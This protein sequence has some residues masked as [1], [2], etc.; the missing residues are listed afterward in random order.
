MLIAHLLQT[1]DFWVFS[2]K[3]EYKFIERKKTVLKSENK[4]NWGYAHY[5]IPDFIKNEN[6]SSLMTL[7][8]LMVVWW[9]RCW[10]GIFLI[11]T[12]NLIIATLDAG[13]TQV[14]SSSWKPTSSTAAGFWP[15]G[16]QV[17]NSTTAIDN[18]ECMGLEIQQYSFIRL[19]HHS[20]NQSDLTIP[21]GFV[22]VTHIRFGKCKCQQRSKSTGLSLTSWTI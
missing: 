10:D 20:D 14:C 6:S 12:H 4:K 5:G 17:K 13:R 18:F 2:F 3:N 16:K 19:W 21:L 9:N 8:V 11:L 15:A 1:K 22:V 7:M